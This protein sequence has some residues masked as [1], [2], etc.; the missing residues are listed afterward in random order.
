MT[1]SPAPR[2]D[3]ISAVS[4][5][6]RV[7]RLKSVRDND[8]R[9][10]FSLVLGGPLFQLLRRAHVSDDALELVRKRIL[11][12]VSLTWLPLLVLSVLEEQAFGGSAP[13]PFLWDVEAHARVAGQIPPARAR[14]GLA[15]VEC[16][17]SAHARGR[18]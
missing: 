8:D 16:L 15:D 2:D 12:F 10:D 1:P 18:G 13:V 11:F 9:L 7:A 3:K 14:G 6:E 17:R 4:P 5:Q